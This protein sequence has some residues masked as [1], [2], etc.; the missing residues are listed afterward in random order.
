[1]GV[2]LAVFMTATCRSS[3]KKAREQ[4]GWSVQAEKGILE[5]IRSR[6]YVEVA[7]EMKTQAK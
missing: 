2:F 1:M 7:K 5:E 6:S 3:N 4:L